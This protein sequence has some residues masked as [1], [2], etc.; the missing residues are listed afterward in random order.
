MQDPVQA[1][2][3][4]T[5]ERA[6]VTALF[7]AEGDALSPLTREVLTPGVLLPNRALAALRDAHVDELLAVAD[8]AAE[9]AEKKRKAA[10]SPGGE[11]CRRR[12]RVI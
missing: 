6:A 7:E 4:N 1:S 9:T 12:G 10:A 8:A 11:A 5:Y 2:D 3:G